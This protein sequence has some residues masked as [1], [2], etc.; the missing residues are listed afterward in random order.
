[1]KPWI[2]FSLIALIVFFFASTPL[3]AQI[4][5]AIKCGTFLDVKNEKELSGIIILIEKDKILHVGPNLPIPADAEVIDLSGYTV[6]PGLIEA[7][8]HL[9]LQGDSTSE[10]YDEQLLKESIPY[11]TIR[12]TLA[13]K[14]AL[15]YGFTSMRDV[16]NEGTMYADVDL[17]K[18]INR[19]I[20]PGPRLQVSTRAVSITGAYP[21]LHYAWELDMPKGVQIVD[22][23]EE[24][25]KAVRE[26]V[27]NGS[28]WIKIYCDRGYWIDTDGGISSKINFTMDELKAMVDEAHR[29]KVKVAAHAIG[30][31]GIRVALDAGVNSIEHGDGF[32]DA[33]IAQAVRQGVY[34]CP[35]MLVSEYVAG[36]RTAAGNPF[37]SKM[38]GILHDSF[39]K[40]VQARMK[41]SLG[42]DAGGYPWTMNPVKEI[43]LM[44]AY[45]MTT[46]QALRAS[47]LVPAELMSWQDRIG[48]I[49]AGKLAD[50]VALK[51]NPVENISLLQQIGFVMKDGKICKNTYGE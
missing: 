35:T 42:S 12:A 34:W 6:L 29:W 22:G 47:T 39:K 43:A 44:A 15:E 36:P 21:L 45:G 19:G 14:T 38:L 30:R 33:L 27:S 20:I 37:W 51:G 26:Q 50:I 23:A 31:D 7:H 32:D 3:S 24:C 16:G 25:R 4:L 8:T 1:M 18:A 13:A 49:E 17:K 41:I 10:A 40:G 5:K 46:W 48:S 11:R 28:D 9:M 2:K